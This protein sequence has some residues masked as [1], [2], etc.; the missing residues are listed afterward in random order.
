MN[1]II[2]DTALNGLYTLTVLQ[3]QYPVH[4]SLFKGT[5]DAAL[6]DVAPF[7]F[8]LNDN[9]EK[10]NG[11]PELSFKA[12]LVVDSN[13]EIEIV[14][15]HFREFIYQKVNGRICYFRFW[16]ARVLKKFLPGC[17][18]LQLRLFFKTVNNITLK[19][20]DPGYVLQYRVEYSKLYLDKALAKEI[21]PVLNI[22]SKETSPVS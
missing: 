12:M 21:C 10:L 19:D 13:Y 11:N 5:K 14:A 20:E 16:D 15:D 17:T 8:L 18:E 2:Y 9:G 6:I 22:I 1:Y 3:Q 7:V 4:Q